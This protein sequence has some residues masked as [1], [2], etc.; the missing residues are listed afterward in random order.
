MFLFR[1]MPFIDLAY[2]RKQDV[3]GNRIVYSRHKTGRQMTVRIPKEAMELMKEFKTG[4]R[5]PS[6]SFRFY[7]DKRARRNGPG[8]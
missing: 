6:I 3:K 1:G 7:T 8:R 4:I 5:I 2:L